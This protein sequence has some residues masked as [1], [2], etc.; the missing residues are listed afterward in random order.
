MKP[1]WRGLAVAAVQCLMVLGLAGKYAWD[2]G[3]L[4][5][6]W[7]KAATI[8]P[9][10]AIRGRYASLY[11]EV[12]VPPGTPSSWYPARL[13]V[14]NG[15]LVATPGAADTGMMVAGLASQ[16]WRLAEPVPFFI[17]EHAADPSLRAAGEELWVEVTVPKKGPPRPLRLGVK[18]D[19][20][21]REL[22][23][24]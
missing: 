22:D 14:E 18:K 8:D 19:G 15:R 12:A 6:V 10:L 1:S 21:L 4:P 17:G 2:R 13:S 3:H 24:H 16:G 20:A 7:V 11:L 9:D 5:R 23:L